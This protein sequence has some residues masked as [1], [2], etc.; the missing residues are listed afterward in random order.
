MNSFNYSIK[1]I[2][3][4]LLIIIALGILLGFLFL[5]V[6]LPL[7]TNHGE[8]VSVPDL[9]GYEYQEASN[10]LENTGLQYEVSLDSGFSTELPALAILKQIPA[11]NSQVKSGRKI[12][13]TLNARN[14]PLIK[15][16]NLVN[17]PLKNVQE[18]LANIGL[19]R[20]D[21]VY[22]PDI[23]INVV[24]EQRYR[25]VTV[26]EGFEIPK[27]AR[28]DLTV[29]DGMGNQL[30]LVPDLTGMEEEDAEFLIL[31]YGLR[32]GNKNFSETDSVAAGK[33]FLQ[34]PP[35]GTEVRTGDLIN[36]WISKN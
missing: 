3:I 17:M 7:Y 10:L 27:G 28:I 12:Y 18:I 26:K 2:L 23:G 11:A 8:T 4:N 14:A 25:G 9:S 33:I 29:G 24:L 5:K 21:I 20:G 6:Y 1:K 19:E 32:L 22:V 13:L 30:L 34:A 15:M 35:A 36:I 16:P 31:G